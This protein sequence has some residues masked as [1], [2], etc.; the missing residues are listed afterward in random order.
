MNKRLVVFFILFFFLILIGKSQS[1]GKTVNQLFSE[2]KIAAE[3]QKL[4]NECWR[5]RVSN[6]DSALLLGEKALD[7][8]LQYNIQ[9]ELPKIYGFIGVIQ[10][11]YLYQTKQSIPNLKNSLKF[12]LQQ[13]DSIQLAYAYNNLGD[14]YLMTGNVALSLRYS[15][16][17]VNLFEKLNHSPGKSYSYVNI[18]LVHRENKE[19][20]LALE[21]FRKALN[22]W[23]DS[24]NDIGIGAVNTEIARTYEILGDLDVAM[25]YYQKSYVYGLNPGKFRYLSVCLNGIANIYYKRKA[26]DKALEYYLKA[27]YQNRKQNH[28]FGSVHNNIGIALV[29]A[30]KRNKK[31]GEKYLD[32]AMSTALKLGVN[33]QIIEVS[34]SYIDFYKILGDYKNATLSSENFHFLYDSLLSAQQFE[35]IN[36]ME[37]SFEARNE[38][39]HAE[40]ELK[41]NKLLEQNLV[42]VIFFMVAII[43]VMI[44]RYRTN[45]SLNKKLE[46]MNQTK[47]KMF[48]VISHDLKN[49]FNSLIGFSE[50]LLAEIEKKDF[51]KSKRFAKYLNQ[52]AVEGLKL[53]TSLLHWSLSQ[54]GKIQFN[55]QEIEFNDIITE[56][57]EFYDAELTQ[58]NI[59]L[60]IKNSV[61]CVQVDPNI[62]RI[63]LMNLI[64]NAIKYTESNGLISLNASQNSQNV[65]IKIQDSGIG[66]S[67]SLVNELFTEKSFTQSKT[68]LR[69]EQGT[70]L[71]LSVVHELVHIHKGSIKVESCEG[72]GTT[73]ELKFP[74]NATS[75]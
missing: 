40:Q 23:K 13:K 53:L 37:R 50:L 62:I 35:I 21:Y 27:L 71:G 54:S 55:P 15:Q 10:L 42:I 66:M 9:K 26:F 38:L 8:A 45:R 52:A 32:L 63:V 75:N 28:D 30:Q 12:S 51:E 1:D 20:D 33:K 16:R 64:S 36:E 61:G 49:P 18:G 48:S 3:I 7:L 34:K 72:R 19:F 74:C 67:K 47:D 4:T 43:G 58:Y 5:L 57:N 17:S 22:I 24:R 2:K 6:S 60:Q 41:T 65:T 29:K 68:G 46:E 70:G 44:W 14:L 11:H 59:E 56:L 25:D 39:L 31:E 69:G 73:F